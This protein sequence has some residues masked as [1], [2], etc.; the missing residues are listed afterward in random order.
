MCIMEETSEI[1]FQ[2]SDL[3]NEDILIYIVQSYKLLTH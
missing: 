1:Q 2:K 3:S